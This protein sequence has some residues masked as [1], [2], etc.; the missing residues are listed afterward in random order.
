MFALGYWRFV[1]RN[2]LLCHEERYILYF[3]VF[4]DSCMCVSTPVETLALVRTPVHALLPRASLR[5][6]PAIDNH[7]AP[8]TYSSDAYV[9]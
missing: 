9:S 6:G 2:R 7:L 8:D 5:R 4:L 3:P 1:L